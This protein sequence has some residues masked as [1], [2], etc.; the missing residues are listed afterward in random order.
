MPSPLGG[1]L[2]KERVM[3]RPWGGQSDPSLNHRV[4]TITRL[5]T[6]L[7]LMIQGRISS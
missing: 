1:R 3:G 4:P 2:W 7:W 5:T 6:Q